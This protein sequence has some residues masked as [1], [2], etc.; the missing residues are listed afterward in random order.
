MGPHLTLVQYFSHAQII[1]TSRQT[2]SEIIFNG[3]WRKLVVF[4]ETSTGIHRNRITTIYNLHTHHPFIR[5]MHSKPL[6]EA[7]SSVGHPR[8][9]KK[10]G[11]PQPWGLLVKSSIWLSS[12]WEGHGVGGCPVVR[13]IICP[14]PPSHSTRKAEQLVTLQTIRI[15]MFCWPTDISYFTGKG[16]KPRI[17]TFCFLTIVQHDT[18]QQHLFR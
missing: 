5:S 7:V 17:F 14:T 13:N 18:I 3:R 4:A 6:D 16:L 15:F 10:S 11:W 12:A 8:G 2:I 1:S 9:G